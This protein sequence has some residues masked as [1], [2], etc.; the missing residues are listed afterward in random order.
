MGNVMAFVDPT[1]GFTTGTC[2][3]ETDGTQTCAEMYNNSIVFAA[4]RPKAEVHA[5]AW[6]Q[7][8]HGCCSGNVRCHPDIYRSHSNTLYGENV[9][10]YSAASQGTE[11]CTMALP[12]WQALNRTM[13]EPGTRWVRD[14]PAAGELLEMG[15]RALRL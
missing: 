1:E 11:A 4:G 10:L 12:E 7:L 6:Q 15:R 9:T 14:W 2:I 13:H 3:Q 5:A 8:Y